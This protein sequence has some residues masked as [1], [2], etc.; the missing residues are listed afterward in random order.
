MKSLRPSPE[1]AAKEVLNRRHARRSL[2]GFAVYTKPSYEVSWHHQLLCHYLDKFASGEIKRLMINM[3]RRHGK[4]ELT[5]RRLPAYLFGRNPNEE[6]IACSYSLDLA[7]RM[8]R[9]VQRVMGTPRYAQLFPDTSLSGG[10]TQSDDSYTKNTSIF[11]IVG[12]TGSYRAAGVGGGVVGMGFTKG[13]I[14]DF[15]K[16]REEADSPT[17]RQ[18]WR[19]WYAGAFAPAQAPGAGILITAT[20]WHREDLCGW[21][22]ELAKNDPKA[23][24]WHV[25]TLPAICEG[26]PHPEDHRKPGEALWPT[27]YPVAE[28]EKIKANSLYEWSGQYQ[29]NPIPAGAT[30]WPAEFFGPHIW[31]DDWPACDWAVRAMGLDPSKGKIDKTGDYSAYVEIR[32]DSQRNIWVDADMENTRPV[33]STPGAHS[34]VADGVDLVR[35]RLPQAV[36]VET[37]GFQELVATALVRGLLAAGLLQAPVYTINNTQPKESRIRSLGTYFAQKRF[38]V[39]NSKG[40]RMLVQ[41]LRDFP[42]GLNDDGPDALK[43]AEVM[44]DYL[45]TGTAGTGRPVILRA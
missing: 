13:I 22:L 38:R 30:E 3:P 10:R 6:I 40:G 25:L 35:T 2:E 17:M 42:N 31:F 36:C 43:I 29:Q 34:I 16:N 8:N 26:E 7:G 32:V 4:S 19:E 44:A 18:K 23:D 41:Q 33:E 1:E 39:R 27:R 15:C 24:Q 37:N 5:S 9:D 21:L 45:L 28:L 12:H 11:E 14:D 20:R